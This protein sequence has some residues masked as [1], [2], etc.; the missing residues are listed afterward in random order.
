[1]KARRIAA[2]VVAAA[3]TAVMGVSGCGSVNP[4]ATVATLNGK[5]ISAGL[6]NFMA[7]MQAAEYDTYYIQ[8]YGANMWTEKDE[9]DGTTMTDVVR[10]DVCDTLK[11]RYLLEEHM[12]DYGVTV[13]DAELKEI[14]TAAKEF[15]T[16]NKE[17][18]LKQMGATED[19]VKEYLR[20]I[21]IEKKMETAIRDKADTNVSD[22]ESAMRTFS[23]YS[24]TMPTADDDT[25]EAD[26]QDVEALAEQVAAMA[27]TD[28]DGVQDTFGQTQSSYS[29]GKDE[30]GFADEVIK[31]ADQLSEGEVSG[32][33]KTEDNAFYVIRLDSEDDEAAR[34]DKKESIIE[35]RKV[36]LYQEVTEGYDKDAEWTV[37][38]QVLK[39]ITMHKHYFQITF[40]EEETEAATE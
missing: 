40:D 24:V 30:T 8:Y 29:Y 31:A 39:T 3:L 6:A 1:M 23:Y 27:Q 12:G 38:D 13:S 5:A 25:A 21:L 16:E 10:E 32:V 11:S 20:T 37:N 14:E 34:A 2:L 26:P 15:M 18:A 36:D 28:F 22:E 35:Q 4:T 33:I 17:E 9:D 19:I 7:Q